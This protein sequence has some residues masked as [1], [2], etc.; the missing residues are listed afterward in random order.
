MK[1][2]LIGKI[3]SG[4]ELTWCSQE[5]LSELKVGFCQTCGFY[6]A[7]PYPDRDFLSRYYNGY[8]IPCP[9]HQEERDRIARIIGARISPS[10]PVIDIGCGKGEMLSTLRAHGFTNLYG[11]EA[12]SM[13]LHASKLKA[14]TMLPYDI[15]ELIR[16]SNKEAKFFDCALL[17][18]VLEHVPEPVSLMRQMKDILSPGGMVMFSIP[19]D[20]NVLQNV[21][22]KK[23]QKKPWFLVLP[24]HLNYISLESI[25]GVMERAGYE[26]IHKTVQYPLELFLLQGDNYTNEPETG[27]I[28]HLKRVEF[29]RSFAVTDSIA[30]LDNLYEVFAKAGIGRDMYILARP[31]RE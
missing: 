4:E 19:N 9:L 21:Y 17:I 28:C 13:R 7:D 2:K 8:E 16:W 10:L 15:E 6:H 27:K 3:Y 31:I 14:I 11:T 23:T 29:E 24:D 18:N 20:F 30:D 22:L 25:D 26:I 1:H 5:T 12:G